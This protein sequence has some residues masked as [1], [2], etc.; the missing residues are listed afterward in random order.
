MNYV[1]QLEEQV[2]S[3]QKRLA[4]FEDKIELYI[5]YQ[6]SKNG[7]INSRRE[8]RYIA[9]NLHI[10]TTVKGKDLISVCNAHKEKHSDIW[11]ISDNQSGYDITSK[12]SVRVTGLPDDVRDYMMT[13]YGYKDFPYTLEDCR[14]ETPKTLIE[15]NK[16][17]PPF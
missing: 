8:I 11:Y 7:L 10:K 12:Q 17:E 13:M 5:R 15:D 14:K 16:D 9:I 4:M 2:D 1:Q 3:L 6:E